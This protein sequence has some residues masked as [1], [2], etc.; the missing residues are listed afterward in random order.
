[1]IL[2]VRKNMADKAFIT[3]NVLK[4]ARE[5]AKMSLEVAAAKAIVNAEKLSLWEQ[6][7]EQPTIKQAEKLA[8]IYRRPFALFF[9]PDV[10]NDFL[11]LQDFRRET[12]VELGTA[13]LFIIREIQQKQAWMSEVNSENGEGP[14]T[15]V[16]KYNVQSK[17]KEVADDILATLQIDPKNYTFSPMKEWINKAEERGIFISR[18]SF[19]HSR[20]KLDSDEIQGFAIADPHAPFIFINSQDWDAPQL[21]TLVHELAHLWIAASGI[22]NELSLSD[23]PHDKLHPIELFCNEVAANALMPEEVVSLFEGSIFN[24][25]NTLLREAKR[26]GVSTFALLVRAKNL[27]LISL[28]SYKMLKAHAEANFKAFE[29]KEAERAEKQKQKTGGPNPYLL[30]LNKNSKLFTQIVLDGFRAGTI[31][32]TQASSLLNTQVNNFHKLEAFIYS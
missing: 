19:I 28:E 10:P 9:L 16:G 23:E 6:G 13:S 2:F 12:S 26:L 8:N 29:L 15:F 20:L 1:M 5:S 3:P 7:T 24:S 4:W 27:K 22:S 14:S 30:R 21:F 32:A 17:P 31:A 11:P 18:T 25:A